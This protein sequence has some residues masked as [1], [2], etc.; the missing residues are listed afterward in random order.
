MVKKQRGPD[1]FTILARK[2]LIQKGLNPIDMMYE[3]FQEAM[4]TYR[5]GP[6]IEHSEKGVSIND[7]R[8]ACLGVAGRMASEM[9][10]YYSPSLSAIKIETSDPENQKQERTIVD[11]VKIIQSDPFAQHAMKIAEQVGSDSENG[12]TPILPIGTKE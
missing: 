10:K 8:A 3:V 6:T 1:T 5:E 11:A 12:S 7:P 9:M 2:E 4:A